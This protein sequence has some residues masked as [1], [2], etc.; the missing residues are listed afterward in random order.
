MISIRLADPDGAPLPAA[1][2]GQYLTVR[3]R[4]GG[5][6]RSVL[7]NYSLSGA[8][9]ADDYRI[10]VKREHDGAASGYLHSRLAV[11]DR[12]EIARTARHLHPRHDGCTR[13]PDQRRHRRNPGSRHAPRARTG[14]LGREIWW[15]HGARDGRDHSFAAEARAL[16]ASLPEVH[17]RICYSRPGPDDVQGRD[18]DESPAV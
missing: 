14:T 5:E 11:G 7:R 18:F 1:R 3:I 12:L 10:T 6:T 9:G 13:S 15:L 17:V 4:L 16:L 2:P 8:P